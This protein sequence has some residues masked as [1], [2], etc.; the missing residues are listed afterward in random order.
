VAICKKYGCNFLLKLKFCFVQLLSFSILNSVPRGIFRK[1]L[2]KIVAKLRPVLL[3]VCLQAQKSAQVH[4]WSI[5]QWLICRNNQNILIKQS[6]YVVLLKV[7]YSF[8][9]HSQHYPMSKL[10]IQMYSSLGNSIAHNWTMWIVKTIIVYQF[11]SYLYSTQAI[12][13]DNLHS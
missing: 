9:V 3:M 12:G 7:F 11:T 6:P 4:R 1:S 10:S 2:L 5:L 8:L 13:F